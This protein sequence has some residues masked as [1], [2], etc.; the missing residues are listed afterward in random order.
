MN[1]TMSE[2]RTIYVGKESVHRI[3]N[4]SK[5]TDAIVAEIQYGDKVDE[6]DI[7]RL[8]DDFNR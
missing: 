4:P 1:Y 7:V 6:D 5:T 3:Y 8:E 2:G